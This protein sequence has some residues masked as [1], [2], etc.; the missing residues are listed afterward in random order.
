[1]GCGRIIRKGDNLTTLLE[2][3]IIVKIPGLIQ[4]FRS[5]LI[6]D[7]SPELIIDLA[8][9]ASNVPQEQITTV[10]I[11]QDIITCAGPDDSMLADPIKVTQFMVKQLAP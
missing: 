5:N 9:M 10:E 3:A 1:V 4:Q 2:K 6:T 11:E 8:C 7:L